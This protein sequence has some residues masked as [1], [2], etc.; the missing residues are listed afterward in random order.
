MKIAIVYYSFTG[1]THRIAQLME[2]VLKNKGNE[3]IPI[4][5][6]PL[7]EETNFIVQCKEAFLS[8]KP[9]LYRTLLDLNDFDRVI[10]GSPVWAFK[11]A[12]AVN[13][14][15]DKCSFLNEKDA[16]CFVTYGSGTGKEKALN[17]M[18]KG[19]EAKGARITKTVSFQQGENPES[20]KKKIESMLI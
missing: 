5:I 1:N 2:D 13:T 10:L 4:R 8:K 15:M 12:P 16:I 14:Y 6:R 17:V 7:K 19:L 11:P 20:S 18:K 3:V 9:D